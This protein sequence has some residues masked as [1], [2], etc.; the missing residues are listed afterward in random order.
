LVD[1]LYIG[2]GHKARQGK[3]SLVR[4][5][6][7]Q[8]PALT[9]VMGFADA[10]KVYCRVA[11][12]MTTKD[13][14]LLQRVGV[15]KRHEDPDFWI[16]ILQYTAQDYPQPII[17]IPDVRFENEAK[18]IDDADGGLIRV[19]RILADGSQYVPSDR[20]PNHESETALD[21][22]AWP[23]TIDIP[24]GDVSVLALRREAVKLGAAIVKGYN[25][26]CRQRYELEGPRVTLH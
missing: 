26:R 13:A 11:H 4:L 9:K 15:E 14:P 2:F 10:L 6:N 18:F 16:K 24:D 5:I 17:L 19:R 3:D 7:Q 23:L 22:Y 1:K 25:E 21:N 12:G 20:D 8:Y